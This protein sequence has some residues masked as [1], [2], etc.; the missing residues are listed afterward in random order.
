MS[1]RDILENV[2]FRNIYNRRLITPTVHMKSPLV[3]DV[4]LQ[5]TLAWHRTHEPSNVGVVINDVIIRAQ[6]ASLPSF[7]AHG[8]PARSARERAS[9]RLDSRCSPSLP[10]PFRRSRSL[11]A[12]P[13]GVARHVPFPFAPTRLARGRGR[14]R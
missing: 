10:S 14:P 6:H 11:P 9:S 7:V 3:D 1:S 5:K 4:S 8:R 2:E 13:L 12:A